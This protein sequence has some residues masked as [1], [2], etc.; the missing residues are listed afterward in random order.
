MELLSSG[1][2]LKDQTRTSSTSS[3]VEPTLYGKINSRLAL[4]LNGHTS[5]VHS[6][7]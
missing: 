3:K 7:T 5:E 4:Q 1:V 2:Y 6:Q